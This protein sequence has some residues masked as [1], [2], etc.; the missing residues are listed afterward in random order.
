LWINNIPLVIVFIGKVASFSLRE[1]RGVRLG[2][3]ETVVRVLLALSMTFMAMG[4]RAAELRDVRLWASPD[5]TRVVF[6][7]DASTQHT[8]FAL[9]NPN[10]VVV[11]LSGTHRGAA[12]AAQLEGKG[13]VER[14]RS[15]P[16]QG[17]GLRV[18]LDL[19]A[20]AKPKSF[21]LQP[22][23]AYGFRVVVDLE[24][25][26]PAPAGTLVASTP[27]S[28]PAAPVQAPPAQAMAP[29]PTPT[30]PRPAVDKPI[31]I[32]IDAGHGGEDPGARSRR[33]LLEKEVSLSL[34]RRLAALVSREP[35]LRAVLIRDGDYYVGLRDR[36][37]KA[38]DAQAD[39]FVSIHANSYK[40]PSVR[41]TAVYVLS[42]KGASSEHALMLA[43]RE[44]MSDL[45][46]GVETDHRDNQTLA[47]LAD[48]FQT[49]AMEASHDAGGRLLDAMSRVNVLQK[50]RVQQASFVVLKSASFPSV[51]VETA[52][53]TN[54]REE[55]M[56]GDPAH[57][58]RLAHS[59]LEGIKGY[60]KS[61]RPQHQIAEAEKARGGLHP[62]SMTGQAAR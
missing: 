30:L 35:G 4:A 34:A 47:V 54:E 60:F 7:L 56:L 61:Y 48:I 17:G 57:Q 42:P 12:L 23:D 62:V 1:Y 11:D 39:L 19:A 8:V 51:L 14:V 52:F 20:S 32:A 9:E 45:I 28:A 31:V 36:I 37:R 26:G 21:S 13:L 41:G 38:H 59:M 10:R 16:Q 53:L 5:G 44:N 29:A 24:S 50:P 27:A 55:R 15:G 22:N 40:D 58:D 43:D 6:D 25:G 18:V 49:S 33:G 46:G 2:V 3:P